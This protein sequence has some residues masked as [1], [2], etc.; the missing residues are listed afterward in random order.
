MAAAA[1]DGRVGPWVSAARRILGHSFRNELPTV[2]I[3]FAN[4]P[5]R[6]GFEFRK[7][8]EAR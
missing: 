6:N 2:T 1:P 8:A 4:H 7:W 5:F 3:I